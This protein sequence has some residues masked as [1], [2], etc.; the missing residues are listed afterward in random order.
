[1]D[2]LH[3]SHYL[4]TGMSLEEFQDKYGMPKITSAEANAEIK[5]SKED[6]EKR[7]KEDGYENYK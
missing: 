3:D 4:P 5:A 6:R 1:M 2:K 7:E